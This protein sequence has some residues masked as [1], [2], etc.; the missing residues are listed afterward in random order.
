M[1]SFLRKSVREIEVLGF[2]VILV[3]VF[4]TISTKFF[5]RSTFV[6][7]LEQSAINCFLGLGV[8]FPIITGG[9]DLSV[10]SIVAVVACAS[11]WLAVQG[12]PP[13]ICILAGLAIGLLVGW[14]NGFL[15]T[16][17]KMQPFIATLGTQQ[18]VRGI[19]YVRTEG[20]P[21]LYVPNPFRNILNGNF[22]NVKI[23]VYFVLVFAIL[24]LF[25]IKRLKL[26]TYLFAIGAN[27]EAAKLSGVNT[28]RNKRIAYC[29]SGFMA[30]FAGLVMV[31]RMGAGE[32]ST[33][34]GYELDAI[35]AA[36]IGG[37]SLAG[38]KGSVIGTILGSLMI[39]ALKIGLI[40]IGMNTFVQ[41]IAVG[42]VILLAV[43][44][45]ELQEIIV[46]LIGR[47]RKK[48]VDVQ[49]GA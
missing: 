37:A 22:L 49:E 43:Y 15:V 18:I 4:S 31:A 17:L 7:I 16:K 21:V 26:G 2:I 39:Y 29:I 14:I 38:G 41:F 10:G 44:L 45:D 30:A 48:S 3:I 23:F 19:G 40:V 11:G 27:E 24:C 25:I 42:I 35:A 8:M 13:Y 1:K 33:A 36:A 12:V 32:P 47:L 46:G 9:I 5:S 6:N 28:E 34:N 20:W